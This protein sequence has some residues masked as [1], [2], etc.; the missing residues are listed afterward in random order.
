[1]KAEIERVYLG[2]QVDARGMAEDG[3]LSNDVQRT[4]IM[5]RKELKCQDPESLV[6]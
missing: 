4:V 2:Y 1:M 5:F 6:T 3:R